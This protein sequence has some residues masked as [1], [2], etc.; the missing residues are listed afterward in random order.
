MQAFREKYDA[1]MAKEFERILAKGRNGQ[2]YHVAGKEGKSYHIHAVDCCEAEL[3]VDD[4]FVQIFPDAPDDPNNHVHSIHMFLD[5][6]QCAELW[7]GKVDA[8][9]PARIDW[10]TNYKSA[11]W[12]LVEKEPTLPVKAFARPST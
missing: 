6:N 5:G 10:V 2:P 12:Y 7:E 11:R 1:M 4:W 8:S 9:D 3:K